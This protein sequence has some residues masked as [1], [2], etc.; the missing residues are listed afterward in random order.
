VLPVVVDTA[1]NLALAPDARHLVFTLTVRDT[2]QLWLHSFAA[3]RTRPLR[4]TEGARGPFWSASG[5]HVA[6]SA[7]GALKRISL[8]GDVV[9]Q[10]C[11]TGTSYAMGTWVA[12]DTVL[13]YDT[14]RQGI[15]RVSAAGGQ[16][17]HTSSPRARRSQP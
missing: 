8:D 12:D 1:T 16:T 7:D 17:P 14:S 3:N 13:F 10:I 5:R 15:A 4:G 2:Q 6:F 11:E 9:R